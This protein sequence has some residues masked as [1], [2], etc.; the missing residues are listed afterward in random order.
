M[1]R[2]F[3]HPVMPRRTLISL[4]LTMALSAVAG[5]LCAGTLPWDAGGDGGA[6]PVERP[7]AVQMVSGQ[8][9]TLPPTPG[10]ATHGAV[11]K[12]FAALVTRAVAALPDVT[13]TGSVKGRPWWQ[14]DPRAGIAFYGPGA[15][16]YSSFSWTKP[17]T[18]EIAPKRVVALVVPHWLPQSQQLHPYRSTTA[19]SAVP[20]PPAAPML[21]AALAGI[22]A[23]RR[24]RRRKG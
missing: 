8:F 19:P 1:T 5:P 3:Q 6:T 24:L 7:D 14:Y 20:L 4:T 17:A 22:A 21:L 15:G 16:G 9:R 23:I 10:D 18:P 2:G 11:S 12:A 13:G